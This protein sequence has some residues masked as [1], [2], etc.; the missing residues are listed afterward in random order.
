MLLQSRPEIGLYTTY[1]DARKLATSY[2]PVR[3]EWFPWASYW[4]SWGFATQG[5]Q[6]QVFQKQCIGMCEKKNR[7]DNYTPAQYRTRPKKIE[8]VPRLNHVKRVNCP[9][10]DGIVPLKELMAGEEKELGG[11]GAKNDTCVRNVPRRE[12]AC[13]ALFRY[14]K[15]RTYVNLMPL[16]MLMSQFRLQWYPS[17]HSPLY[18]CIGIY[19]RNKM[20]YGLVRHRVL[21]KERGTKQYD[22][23]RWSG[24]W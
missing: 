10:S 23:T 7:L 15:K 16:T 4:L 20:V 22:E 17:R 24:A 13:R 9:N 21:E 18:S 11:G 12:N 5:C 2:R 19:W 3:W 1:G 14:Q 6:M 8:N